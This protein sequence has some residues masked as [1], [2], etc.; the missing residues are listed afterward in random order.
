[1]HTILWC[2]SISRMHT[3]SW[4]LSMLRIHTILRWGHNLTNCEKI[5]ELSHQET[6]NYVISRLSCTHESSLLPPHEQLVQLSQGDAR[7][8]G[9]TVIAL[10]A[11]LGLFHITQQRI[12]LRNAQAA[13]CP[14][15]AM[16]GHGGQQAVDM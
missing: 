5:S 11:A 7:P 1:M 12:H 4:C 13:V 2:L 10:A 16:T 8:G 9:A 3:I 6:K 14:D 15:R